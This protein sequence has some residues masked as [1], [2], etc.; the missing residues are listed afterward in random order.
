MWR[1]IR[2]TSGV[3]R[4][5]LAVLAALNLGWGTWALLAPADFFATFPGLG[6][7]WTAAYPPYNEHLVTDLGATFLTLGVLLAIAGVVRSRDVRATAL[8]AV[9]VFNVLHLSFHASH[10]GTLSTVDYSA[11]L[12]AL[13][14]GVLLPLGLLALVLRRTVRG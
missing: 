11:S 7:H 13:T 4:L 1:M 2:S 6:H 5:G 9:T 10:R 12:A 14:G 8:V 3:T